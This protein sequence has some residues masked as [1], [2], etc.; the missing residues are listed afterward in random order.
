MLATPGKLSPPGFSRPSPTIPQRCGAARPRPRLAPSFPCAL[1]VAI[2][3]PWSAQHLELPSSCPALHSLWAA[4]CYRL[5]CSSAAPLISVGNT[6]E[7]GGP[8]ALSP[9]TTARSGC[10]LRAWLR[11]R[12]IITSP[13]HRHSVSLGLS[14]PGLGTKGRGSWSGGDQTSPF[15]PLGD[16]CLLCPLSTPFMSLS[17][18]P[19]SAF[20]RLRLLRSVPTVPSPLW[21]WQVDCRSWEDQLSLFGTGLDGISFPSLCHRASS[22]QRFWQTG[23]KGTAPEATINRALGVGGGRI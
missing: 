2:S 10:G 23:P 15:R 7:V 1:A 19:L 16:R 20:P 3:L 11:R 9:S 17:S 18:P 13:R 5:P 4:L 22:S 6:W 21:L 8:Q 12:L 14:H